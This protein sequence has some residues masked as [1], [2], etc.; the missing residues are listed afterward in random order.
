MARLLLAAFGPE[1]LPDRAAAPALAPRPRPQPLARLAGRERSGCPCVATGNVHAHER[2]RLAL[3]DALVAVRLG[4]TLDESEGL[5][6]GNTA[7]ALISPARA[8]ARFRDHPEA[9]AESARL[10]ERLRFDLTSELGY[11]YPGA[12]DPTAGRGGWRGS[13]A[14][15]LDERYA[16]LARPGPGRGPPRGGARPDRRPGAGRLLP[17]PPRDAGAGARGRARGARPGVRAPPAAARAR[18]GAPASA[19]SSAT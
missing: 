4:A 13:A 5:R 6:R 8:A 16:R 15:S 17:A 11:S 3:Q 2:S 19:R 9:V 7:A 12:E 14:R 18:A 10:A 1:R